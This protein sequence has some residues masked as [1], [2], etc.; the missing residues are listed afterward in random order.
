MIW[1]LRARSHVF[2]R[3]VRL[4]W[5]VLRRIRKN[6]NGYTKKASLWVKPS[7][8]SLFDLNV[9]SQYFLE[10]F[11]SCCS[12]D[13]EQVYQPPDSTSSTGYEFKYSD[14]YITDVDTIDS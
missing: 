11:L 13:E 8:R 14:N 2:A 7:V 12:H 4:R 10:V 3:F 6:W 9:N 5:D 1:R